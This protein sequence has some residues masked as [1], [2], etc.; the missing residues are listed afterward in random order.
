MVGQIKELSS[1]IDEVAPV[2]VNLDAI[3]STLRTSGVS[4][5]EDC[6]EQISELESLLDSQVYT[7]EN[8]TELDEFIPSAKEIYRFYDP[9]PLS[10]D[11]KANLESSWLKFDNTLLEL[12]ALLPTHY[13]DIDD[14]HKTL[15]K[16]LSKCHAK[17]L[18]CLD[19]LGLFC[20]Y[21]AVKVCL[22]SAPGIIEECEI[23][24][25]SFLQCQYFLEEVLSILG[26]SLPH[27]MLFVAIQ[28]Y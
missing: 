23:Y 19:N 18:C 4:S 28:L 26:K 12:Q 7:V 27:G 2:V 5:T 8:K 3:N 22:E 14:K 10:L 16:R 17:I 15:Q 20:A 11:L 1:C 6:E 9:T 25:K 24:R 21:E 13:G